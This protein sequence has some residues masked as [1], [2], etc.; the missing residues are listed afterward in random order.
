MD[1][2]VNRHRMLRFE[3]EQDSLDLFGGCTSL[4]YTPPTIGGTAKASAMRKI[5]TLTTSLDPGTIP[6]MRLTCITPDHARRLHYA[7]VLAYEAAIR[8]FPRF[9]PDD[10]RLSDWPTVVLESSAYVIWY[11]LHAV[12]GM[13]PF[14]I[15]QVCVDSGAAA[16]SGSL[17]QVVLRA[18]LVHASVQKQSL[19]LQSLLDMLHPVGQIDV[20]KIRIIVTGLQKCFLDMGGDARAFEK[21]FL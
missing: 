14:V 3:E 19:A 15:G 17:A 8:G 6:M 16:A 2:L 9:P 7:A 21:L 5:P 20:G 11:T 18:A 10:F 1:E 4:M 13:M 12:G